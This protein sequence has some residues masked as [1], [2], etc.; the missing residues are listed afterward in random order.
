MLRQL[1]KIMRR[2]DMIIVILLFL[3][4]FL[5]LAIFT[6]V[7]ASVSDDAT[8]IAVVKMDNEIIETITLTGNRGTQSFEI[9]A[10]DGDI[11]T[12]EIIDEKIRI[13]SAT[14]PDQVCILTS[15][16]ENLGETIV[17]IPHKVVIEI[18]AENHHEEL[19][20]SS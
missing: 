15:F 7:Q 1:I 3:L 17:C 19:L 18:Q 11:N 10:D 16:I 14:C 2:G 13:R 20:I 6:Y 9:V 5:P 12:V 8:K 4:S